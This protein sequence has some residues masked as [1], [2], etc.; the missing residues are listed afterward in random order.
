MN[1][2]EILYNMHVNLSTS[3]RPP[4]TH[5]K[6]FNKEKINHELMRKIKNEDALKI[7]STE[8]LE[9]LKKKYPNVLFGSVHYNP[10]IWVKIAYNTIMKKINDRSEN[11]T[12]SY[13]NGCCTKEDCT[14]NLFYDIVHENIFNK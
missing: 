10:M 5:I 1:F 2:I 8:C 11:N 7:F 6:N 14:I 9:S 12:I 13:P 3:D 4:F